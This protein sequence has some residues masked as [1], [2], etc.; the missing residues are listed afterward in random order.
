MKKSL[1][2]ILCFGLVFSTFL[3][4]TKKHKLDNETLVF[5]LETEPPT[6][7]PTKTTDTTSSLVIENLFDGLLDYDL[8]NL[9]V[10]PKVAKSWDI[11]KNALVYTFHLR[12]DVTWTDGKKVTAYD[13]EY[14]WKRM[15]DPKTAAEYAYFLFDVK[16]AKD[17]NQGK[18]KDEKQLGIQ[19]LNDTT[20]QVTLA[21]PVAYFIHVA[22]FP[23]LMPLRRDV[24]EKHG[25]KWIEPQNIVT[26][27]PFILTKWK[28]DYEMILTRNE[29]YFGP[30]A[31]LKTIRCLMVTEQSTALSLY[32]TKK[33]DIIRNLPALEIPKLKTS[34]DYRSGN[35]LGSY[36]IGF[37]TTKYPLD[38]K[39]VRR[40]I[41]AAID[42][43]Q[44]TDL[45]EKGDLAT[46]S[47]I[48]KGLLGYNEKIGIPYNV[49]EA[50]S[51]MKKAGYKLQDVEG[52]KQW[53]DTETKKPFPTITVTFNTNEAHKTVIENLQ[54]QWKKNLYIPVEIN[55]Q[56]WK[57]YIDSLHSARK[58][59]DRVGFHIFRL[60]WVA[61]YPDPDN[62]MSLFTSYSDNNNTG[63]ANPKFDALV[64]KAKVVLDP[65]KRAK[66]YDQAQKILL[67]EDAAILPI[68]IY[69]HQSMWRD[70]VQGIALNPLD[71]W[72]LDEIWVQRKTAQK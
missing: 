47:I 32:Q 54:Q 19:A 52:E 66:L 68:Y 15:I 61:D 34:A 60:G 37:L 58:T 14:S 5:N 70:E 28:H 6:V 23:G 65:K 11:S 57:V 7:D 17:F 29:N 20:F 42:R 16:G 62:F 31:K 22:T 40:A 63:W 71:S 30:K 36:Y 45:L 35:F 59:P 46:T 1:Y 38:N 21:Q 56:E 41:T 69:A 50:V 64:E 27:G 26:N 55:N 3:G 25:D 44:I 48:P 53:V 12:D 4:C 9:T 51:W 24:I 33:L 49:E 13:F 67:E 10:V 43:N 2:F 8:P 18:L 39:Y 72:K